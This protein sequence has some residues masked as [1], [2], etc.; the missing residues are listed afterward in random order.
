M[1]SQVPKHVLPPYWNTIIGTGLTYVIASLFGI[2][3][4]TA[5][6]LA[7]TS[8]ELLKDKGS[9]PWY[10]LITSRS[11]RLFYRRSGV[12]QMVI[13][14]LEELGLPY[15][16]K[17]IPFSAVKSAPFTDLNP[18]GRV[19][20]IEDPN[21]DL[22]LWESGAVLTYLAQ[23]Y[24]KNQTLTYARGNEVHHINQWLYFQTSGQG[25]YYGQAAW[26]KIHHPERVQSAIDR[27]I[28]EIKRVLGVLNRSLEGREWLVGDKMTIADMAF[29]PYNSLLHFF[30]EC[31]PE[32]AFNDF[33]NVGS[34][35]QR[36]TLRDSW[37]MVTELKGTIEINV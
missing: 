23:E 26:F 33:P 6:I 16:I 19:P 29:V 22:V 3:A 30:F 18:N 25:P 37:K 12:Y 32:D 8:T 14:V 10:R 34:W 27:Y 28:N 1:L 15:E 11:S 21:R 13:F 4:S 36:M 5:A 9:Y 35:H 17:V 7:T 24:D 31:Q 20:V 2:M